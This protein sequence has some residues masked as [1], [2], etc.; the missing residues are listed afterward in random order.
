MDPTESNDN[1]LAAALASQ[2]FPAEPAT[3]AAEPAP[4]PTPAAAAEP[5]P[6]PEP[7]QTPPADL[8]DLSDDET[9]EFLKKELGVAEPEKTE[10]AKVDKVE[11]RFKELKEE[12]KRLKTE[13]E[14]ERNA[15][16]QL[17]AKLKEL[18]VSATKAKEYEAK[19][20]EYENEMLVVKLEKTQ[21]FQDQVAKPA[22][23]IAT[24][25]GKIAERYDIDY[26]ALAD[27]IEN[28][29]DE[30][31]ESKLNDL[32]SGLQVSPMD[33]VA[34]ANARSAMKPVME[35]REQLYANADKALLEL[36]ARGERETAEQIAAR[37][38]ERRDA[39]PLITR[40]IG[41][42]IPFAKTMAEEA[43]QEVA[44]IDPDALPEQEKV[45][46]LIARKTFSKLATQHAA[47]LKERDELLEELAAYRQAKPGVSNFT[48]SKGEPPK[49]LASALKA[50]LGMA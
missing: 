7:P 34:L 36:Q 28:P 32:L 5:T 41:K 49:D 26:D 48:R 18:E 25:I 17:E 8:P 4:E 31:Y 20:Q 43:A 15:K 14:A 46:N 47:I 44:D 9:P 27:A 2:L 50:G 13:T 33:V 30:A 23:E 11:Y 45:Y 1:P 22:R 35:K 3:P 19:L 40:Q 39:V 6:A 24:K 10:D 37:A 21:A 38:E 42:F 29:E 12:V 16:A